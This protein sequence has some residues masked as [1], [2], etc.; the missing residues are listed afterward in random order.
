MQARQLGARFNFCINLSIINPI[1]GASQ[2]EK[3]ALGACLPAAVA[4]I[5]EWRLVKK[6][7]LE[8]NCPRNDPPP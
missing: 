1:T 5:L 2:P 4:A 8:L 3:P 7:E 6:T